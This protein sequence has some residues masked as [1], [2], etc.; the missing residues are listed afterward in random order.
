MLRHKR[1]QADLEWRSAALRKQK[2]SF[3]RAGRGRAARGMD[4]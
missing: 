4:G 2:C 1:T 3:L